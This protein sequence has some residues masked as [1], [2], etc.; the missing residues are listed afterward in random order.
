VDDAELLFQVMSGHDPRV[1]LSDLPPYL[2]APSAPD[3]RGWRVGW[4][5]DLGLA[6]VD[7]EIRAICAE[8]LSCL[9]EAGA[10]VEEAA[11]DISMVPDLVGPLR[12]A[13]QVAQDQSR[14]VV[15]GIQNEFVGQY[16]DKAAV[17]S[18][19][20]V[21]RA[22]HLRSS[23]WQSV[24]G[25]FAAHELLVTVSTQVPAFPVEE[26]FPPQI[27]GRDI[28]DA[29]EASITC[30][31]ITVTGLPAISI[32]VGRTRSGLPV[33]LQ[34]IGRRFQEATLFGIA[35]IFEAA[36]PWASVRPSL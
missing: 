22:E 36:R 18:A 15:A 28:A 25:F 24:A 26:M 35:R 4:S 2:P 32:P 14:G 3:V 21:G 10:I 5:P 27:D 6:A 9:M 12:A 31:A 8:A 20:E 29:I 17:Y 7:P 13:R 30:Y 11:P 33:G 34:V 16:V 1:P 23:L 19:G